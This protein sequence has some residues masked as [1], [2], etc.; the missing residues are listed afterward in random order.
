MFFVVFVGFKRIKRDILLMTN[1][2]IDR[3]FDKTEAKIAV[4]AFL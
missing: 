1:V 4:F 3:F 2:K